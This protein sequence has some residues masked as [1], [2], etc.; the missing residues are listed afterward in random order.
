MGSR[1]WDSGRARRTTPPHR[2]PGTDQSRRSDSKANCLLRSACGREPD[3]EAACAWRLYP[4]AA[5]P[6]RYP[7]I[8]FWIAR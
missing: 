4:A 8:T 1:F 7:A 5:S 3:A 2:L 6:S